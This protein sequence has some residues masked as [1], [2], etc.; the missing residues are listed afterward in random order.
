MTF[1]SAHIS[2][3]LHNRIVNERGAR[4]YMHVRTMGSSAS[5]V[6]LKSSCLSTLSSFLCSVEVFLST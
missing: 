6:F 2:G 3:N 5:D 4:L 1:I